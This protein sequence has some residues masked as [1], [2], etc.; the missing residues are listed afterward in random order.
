MDR[1][2][3]ETIDNRTAD[4]IVHSKVTPV[5]REFK[6]VAKGGEFSA[7][8]SGRQGRTPLW[9]SARSVASRIKC[10]SLDM[11]LSVNLP[12]QNTNLSRLIFLSRPP[13]SRGGRMGLLNLLRG[14]F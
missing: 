8:S 4:S 13:S 6:R 12:E 5:F 3:N 11:T 7:G 1:G 10:S 9:E 2:R 14:A